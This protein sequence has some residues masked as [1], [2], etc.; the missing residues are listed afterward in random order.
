MRECERVT[1][2][3]RQTQTDRHRQTD[4]DRERE[5][6]G[7]RG[8]ET[9]THS[10][11]RAHAHTHTHTHTHSHTHTHIICTHRE[12]QEGGWGLLLL[13]K[14]RYVQLQL[15]GLFRLEQTHRQQLFAGLEDGLYLLIKLG[16]CAC[17][18]HDHV[19][20]G[21]IHAQK[22]RKMG[23]AVNQLKQCVSACGE[24]M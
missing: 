19:S 6:R 16:L 21:Q 2:R 15:L 18:A 13:C 9:F 22:G 1:D 17:V 3:H 8:A 12:W 11:T 24:G 5:R 14:P 4:T 10:H 7:G 23:D 20:A